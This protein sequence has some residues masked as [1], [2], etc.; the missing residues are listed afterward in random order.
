MWALWHVLSM[1]GTGA[2]V[3]FAGFSALAEVSPAEA[4]AASAGAAALA[5]VVGLRALRLDHEIHSRAGD[6][7][8]RIARNRQR[9][10]RGF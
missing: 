4:A 10:R 1:L 6:P 7:D 9:E 2:V 3:L 5:A 8:L